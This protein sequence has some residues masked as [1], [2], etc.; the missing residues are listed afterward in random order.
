MD[1]VI[2]LVE[3]LEDV[4]D[5]V[6]DLYINIPVPVLDYKYLI[7]NNQADHLSQRDLTM[8]NYQSLS[9]QLKQMLEEENRFY[10]ELSLAIMNL[11]AKKSRGLEKSMISLT[12]PFVA[13][14]PAKVDECQISYLQ[15]RH[16]EEKKRKV[17]EV[18]SVFLETEQTFSEQ[19]QPQNDDEFMEKD[20]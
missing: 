11:C 16:S 7:A 10:K 4:P 13:N 12:Q 3:I 1:E 17:N 19:N 9:T 8:F 18:S 14:Y 2:S 5:M 15:G 20:Y 6:V